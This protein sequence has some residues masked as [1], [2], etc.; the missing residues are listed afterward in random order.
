MSYLVIFKRNK[1]ALFAH[2]LLVFYVFQGFFVKT[3]VSVM[4]FV[5]IFLIFTGLLLS[6]KKNNFIKSALMYLTAGIPCLFFSFF[7]I[8]HNSY[9]VAPVGFIVTY[10]YFFL[11]YLFFQHHEKRFLDDYMN[12]FFFSIVL[13]GA[14]SGVLGMYQIFVDTSIGGYAMNEIYG[15]VD[16][17]SSGIHQSRATGLF[18][19][20]QNYGCFMG[21]AF[22]IAI[23]Y[24][25]KNKLLWYICLA[26]IL[27]GIVVSNSRSA[28]SCAL[29]GLTLGVFF[30][31]RGRHITNLKFIRY[32]L[33]LGAV[34]FITYQVIMDFDLGK[35]GR[36]LNFNNQ[37]AR[38]VYAK[39]YKS[40]DITEFIIGH[41]FGYRN[42]TVNQLLG[43]TMY[44]N[45]FNET[46]TSCESFFMTI[47]VQGGLI[48]LIPVLILMIKIATNSYRHNTLPIILCIIVNMLFTPSL[49]GL[50]I[51]FICWPILLKELNDEKTKSIAI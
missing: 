39:T 20:A 28:S 6:K 32:I 49:T 46:Y 35:Y 22:C 14:I 41:G 17:M 25:F 5:F 24:R 40:T 36:L 42:Y 27:L 8:P 7:L 47:W 50:S 43:E 29:I 12:L 3:G 51:S 13:F 21:L 45:S 33:I 26:V 15:D 9:I 34:A 18:G 30:Y 1:I 4:Q 19:S 11:W 37:L 38:D 31:N 2:M 16:K 44:H 10:L 23:F 48:L